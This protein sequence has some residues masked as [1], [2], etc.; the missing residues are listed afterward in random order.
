MLRF[1]DDGVYPAAFA[2]I[3]S[4]VLMLHGDHDSHPGELIRAGLAPFI[5]QLQYRELRHC[6]HEP[7]AERQARDEFFTLLRAWLTSRAARP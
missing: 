3:Q 4:P 5:G 7:W 6:G 1:Q 2:A